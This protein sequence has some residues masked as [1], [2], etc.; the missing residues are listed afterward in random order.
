MRVDNFSH[1][2]KD[3]LRMA[4]DRTQCSAVGLFSS[5]LNAHQSRIVF[6]Q[7]KDHINH[8]VSD[9]KIKNEFLFKLMMISSEPNIFLNI[10]AGWRSSVVEKEYISVLDDCLRT[11]N[12]LYPEVYESI[13]QQSPIYKLK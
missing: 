3:K 9:K 13:N 11:F 2:I 8:L 10:L 4:S 1:S 7:L 6:D 5:T 12:V